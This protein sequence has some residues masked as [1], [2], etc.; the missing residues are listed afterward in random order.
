MFN[1]YGTSTLHME[2]LGS[3]QRFQHSLVVDVKGE[4]TETYRDPVS[5]A[6]SSY[7]VSATLTVNHVESLR[8]CRRT[9]I[10]KRNFLSL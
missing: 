4:T 2:I 9:I 3:L 10:I 8:N 5:D 7:A 1:L 6:W